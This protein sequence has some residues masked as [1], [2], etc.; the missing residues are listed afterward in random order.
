V[1]APSSQPSSTGNY[2]LAA[3]DATIHTFMTGLNQTSRGQISSPYNVDEWTF[4]ALANQQIKF[5]LLSSTSDLV[6]FDLTG[7]NGASV[8]SGLSASSDLVT[9]PTSG[10][11]VLRS[12]T[13]SGATGAYVFRLDQTSQTDLAVG[14]AYQ[15]NLIGTGQAQLFHIAVPQS[16][17][18]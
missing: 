2:V 1:Q 18:L 16:Q 3:W 15:G 5:D 13:V 14:A 12:Y 6:R 7:P 4:S 17:N 9:L 8:F 10:T 11:Y